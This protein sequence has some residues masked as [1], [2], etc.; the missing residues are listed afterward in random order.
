MPGV[1]NPHCD[2]WALA[3]L[4]WTGCSLVSVEPM[5]STVVIAIPCIAHSGVRQAFTAMCLNK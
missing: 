1:Q 4:S 5:P 3:I 2:P